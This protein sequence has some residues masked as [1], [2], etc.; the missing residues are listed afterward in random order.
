VRQSSEKISSTR[1]SNTSARVC[2][3]RRGNEGASNPAERA[4]ASPVAHP[5]PCSG[6]GIC[7]PGR[8]HGKPLSKMALLKLPDRMG[9][10]NAITTHGFRSTFR[11]WA[12]EQTSHP[13]DVVEMALSANGAKRPYPVLVGC[14]NI[15]LVCVPAGF[16][17][18]RRGLIIFD[19]AFGAP[20]FTLARRCPTSSTR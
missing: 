17:P 5:R 19:Y 18:M 13:R 16:W 20:P 14:W 2:Q 6:G 15:C 9:R 1:N 7:L 10:R 4:R 8:R 12:A 3:Q 11:D